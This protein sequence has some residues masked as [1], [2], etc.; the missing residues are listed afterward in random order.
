MSK[1]ES[2]KTLLVESNG[3]HGKKRA[4]K[5]VLKITSLTVDN[6]KLTSHKEGIRFISEKVK[7]S[8]IVSYILWLSSRKKGEHSFN[9]F[10]TKRDSTKN[11]KTSIVAD[12]SNLTIG[13]V[14]A[15]ELLDLRS[16]NFIGSIFH[17]TSFIG[18][19]LRNA[20]FCGVHLEK[21]FFKESNISFVDFSRADLSSCSFD[22]SYCLA[23][24]SGIEG[25]KF[26]STASCIRV[27][28]DIKNEIA[29]KNEQQRLLDNKRM[30]LEE[31]KKRTPLVTRIGVALRLYEAVGEYNKV[32]NEYKKMKEG[33]FL[34]DHIIHGSFSNIFNAETFVFDPI[35]LPGE[36]YSNN[37]IKKKYIT[38]TRGHLVEYLKRLKR[39]KALS[40]NDFAKEL[41]IASIPEGAKY[42]KELNIIADLSS[43]INMFGN[44][45]WNR[46]DLSELDFTNADLSGANF[47]GSNL[48]NSN[49]KGANITN[50]SFESA[51][52]TEGVF[53]NTVA[54]NSN[55]YNADI[56]D[57][58]LEKSDFSG[59][60]FN[61]SK[62]CGA[63]L[64][65]LKMDCLQA[66]NSVWKLVKLERISLNNSDFT[67]AD[68]R[69]AE[70][71]RIQA[72]SSLFNESLLNNIHFDGC[73][74]DKS[75]FNRVTAIHTI[76]DNCFANQIEARRS[77]FTGSKFAEGSRF[78]KSDFS[79]SVFDGVKA[80]RGHFA[81]AVLNHIKAGYTKFADSCFEK[82][83]FKFADLNSCLMSQSNCQKVDFTGAKLFN[84]TM[85]GANLKGSA[86]VGMEVEDSDLSKVNFEDS[87][88]RDLH[89]KDS[90]LNNINNHRICIN[91]NTMVINCIYKTLDGQFYH[92]DEDNFMDIMFIEQFESNLK[93]VANAERIRKLGFLSFALKWFSKGHNISNKEV[94]KLYNYKLHNKNELKKYLKKLML[95][96]N[97][98]QDARLF[99]IKNLY[100]D[101]KM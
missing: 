11:T 42:D 35:F 5:R 94:K 13:N 74:F 77:N 80:P 12:F 27:Y 17:N 32:R 90:I 47:A 78:E 15:R 46:L 84:V 71:F 76:W 69:G 44:N 75:L 55:F 91:D 66:N 24:W 23:P 95:E 21:V 89:I 45:E 51:L 81:G 98:G 59:A 28:A 56:T 49:F 54:V 86:L 62:C 6:T 60:I 50:A 93:R 31:I 30:Q 1:S 26:S 8:D 63:T 85:I 73:V 38:L 29:K 34:L 40:L 9:H 97:H 4:A 68:F 41:Y 39:T 16:A 64:S 96:K 10:L 33:V 19:D 2:E 3:S 22:N 99:R 61:W 100:N 58:R 82:A 52:L 43:K 20:K 79:Y 57:S 92:Y 14:K 87:N 53:I 25:V 48:K 37:K 88:W 67:S 65:D 7:Q 18:C 72:R 36:V 70:F 83:S 101:N